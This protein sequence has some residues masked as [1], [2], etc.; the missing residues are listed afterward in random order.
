MSKTKSN[1]TNKIGEIE[2]HSSK[3][4]WNEETQKYEVFKAK[5]CVKLY[6]T[7]YILELL[8]DDSKLIVSFMQLLDKIDCNNIIGIKN[9][10][11]HHY[12]PVT[13]KKELYQAMKIDDR[14]AARVY[15]KLT[16]LGLIRECVI[17][18]NTTFFVNPI[19]TMSGSGIS[20]TCFKLF[21]AELIEV[22]P[23]LAIRAL[24][25]LCFRENEED[26]NRLWLKKEEFEFWKE[27]PTIWLEGKKKIRYGNPI[28]V[29]ESYDP[30]LLT[31]A[32]VFQQYILNHEKPDIYSKIEDK[33]IHGTSADGVNLFFTPNRIK[34]G[35][36][37]K[38]ENI[39]QY[40]N[41]FFDFD[42][43]KDKDNNYF[44][45]K[46]VQKR[47]KDIKKVIDTL[48]TPTMTV[49]TRNGYHVYYS[50]DELDFNDK[51]GWNETEKRIINI[52]K[53]ADPAVKDACRI[54]RLPNSI[55][56]KSG[57]EPFEVAIIESCAVRYSL[58]L[59]NEILD[60]TKEKIEAEALKYVE[61]Y[62]IKHSNNASNDYHKLNT[63]TL[64][65]E[66]IE[67]IKN[68]NYIEL[69]KIELDKK[70]DITKQIKSRS[71]AELLN[72]DNQNSFNCIFHDDAHPS[73]TIYKNDSGDR[74]ICASSEFLGNN[75]SR[76]LDIIDVVQKLA[77]VKYSEAVSYL[78]SIFFK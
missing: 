58:D 76:G 20:L 32:E 72:I 35:Q 64:Q 67:A 42:C 75:G 12:Y 29:D 40:R 66:R 41:L 56:K 77:N 63:S 49:E 13:S 52:V 38:N 70:E 71:I 21:H 19:Y 73:A 17:G 23:P 22:L 34:L 14:N 55:H 30:A 3:Q 24:E 57:T 69:N 15:K 39:D 65:N 1:E 74:Y 26:P 7:S 27:T 9:K 25:E 61:K 53:I 4:Y 48:P 16:E 44:S 33:L 60:N 31:D 43:G 78:M 59:M 5:K 47:K 6:N 45:V 51:N 46:E 2:F 18:K 50:L 8:G 10:K 37:R 28:I 11:N 62:Q 54:L 68:L 36:A